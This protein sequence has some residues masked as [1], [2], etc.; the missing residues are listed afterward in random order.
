MCSG[1]DR[2]GGNTDGPGPV[3]LYQER[4][5]LHAGCRAGAGSTNPPE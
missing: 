4:T 1:R 5:E 2:T 3:D